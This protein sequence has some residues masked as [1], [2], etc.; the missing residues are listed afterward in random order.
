[1]ETEKQRPLPRGVV[2]ISREA[3]R[4]FFFYATLVMFVVWVVTEL[5]GG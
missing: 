1:M 3:E 2:R 4:K 5:Y